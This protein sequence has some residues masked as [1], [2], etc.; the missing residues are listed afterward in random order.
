MRTLMIRAL[1]L[2][3]TLSNVCLNASLRDIPGSKIADRGYIGSMSEHELAL[4]MNGYLWSF[5]LVPFAQEERL[6]FE[7]R[8]IR[9]VLWTSPFFHVRRQDRVQGTAYDLAR[10]FERFKGTYAYD[11]VT[12]AMQSRSWCRS[13]AGVI[14]AAAHACWEKSQPASF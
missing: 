4:W 9:T 1:I 11:K 8:F 2:V 5:S 13:I 6:Q 3:S 12:N 7:D 10:T 14:M